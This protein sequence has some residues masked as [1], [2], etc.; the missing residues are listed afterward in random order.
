LALPPAAVGGRFGGGW[1]CDGH[2]RNQKETIPNAKN[3]N[4]TSLKE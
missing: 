3:A 2:E 4:G 1:V